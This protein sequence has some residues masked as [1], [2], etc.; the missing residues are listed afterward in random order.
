LIENGEKD[1]I[2]N[3]FIK[4]KTNMK[5]VIII[6]LVTTLISQIVGEFLSFDY[7]DRFS[8]KNILSYDETLKKIDSLYYLNGFDSKF[9]L[10]SVDVFSKGV[11]HLDHEK[12]QESKLSIIPF[13]KNYILWSLG[14][15]DKVFLKK[16]IFYPFETTNYKLSLGRGY[17][18][19]SQNSLGYSDLLYKKY[20]INLK[21]VGLNGHVVTYFKNDTLEFF[22]DPSLG[23]GFQT[24]YPNIEN[25]YDEI[26]ELISKTKFSELYQNSGQLYNI[27]DNIIPSKH[28]PEGYKPKTYVFEKILFYLKYI[29]LI[30]PILFLSYYKR[31][32]KK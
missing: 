15:I 11:E 22:L 32:Y 26:N 9:L 29:S 1:L 27:E 4:V 19:C 16:R 31:F 28:G 14:Y 17:G 23:I 13:Y 30:V 20:D 18:I 8:N 10:N 21:V 24:D 5:K 12:Y 7:R 6:L 2:L 3:Q 25:Q